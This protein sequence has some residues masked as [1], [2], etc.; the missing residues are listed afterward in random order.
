M[1]AAFPLLALGL[2]SPAWAAPPPTPELVCAYVSPG[3]AKAEVRL[4]L[5]HDLVSTTAAIVKAGKTELALHQSGPSSKGVRLKGWE[6]GPRSTE[7]DFTVGKQA[8]HLSVEKQEGAYRF[9][10]K[11]APDAL[12]KALALKSG[13]FVLVVDPAQKDCAQATIGV[14]TRLPDGSIR[15][16]YRSW[17][18]G[19]LAEA[20]ETLAPADPK[21]KEMLDHLGGLEKGQSKP[22]PEFPPSK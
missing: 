8:G 9:E 17:D 4:V 21:H 6:S 1:R 20:Q 15:A 16:Q 18:H 13:W 22:I 10:M 3:G 19:M 5:E 12:R 14:A 2:A 11:G 7:V